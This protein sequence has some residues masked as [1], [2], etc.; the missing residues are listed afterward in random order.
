MRQLSLNLTISSS[1]PPHTTLSS[2]LI[3]AAWR[4]LVYGHGSTTTPRSGNEPKLHPRKVSFPEGTKTGHQKSLEI[5]P[6]HDRAQK[7][8]PCNSA[9]DDEIGT[10]SGLNSNIGHKFLTSLF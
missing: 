8:V 5:E 4:K 2:L 1:L 9:F 6:L 10:G 7:P 3:P